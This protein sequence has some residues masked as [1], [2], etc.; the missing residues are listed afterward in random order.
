MSA[1]TLKWA[2]RRQITGIR[3]GERC[4]LRGVTSKAEG[5]WEASLPYDAG[6]HAL[7]TYLSEVRSGRR[8]RER[9][10]NKVLFFKN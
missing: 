7:G 8:E 2:L 9:R 4:G 3:P 5:G 1:D 6:I 10:K